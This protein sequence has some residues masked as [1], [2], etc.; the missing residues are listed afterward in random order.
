[1]SKDKYSDMSE[2]STFGFLIN[3]LDGRK[4]ADGDTRASFPHTDAEDLSRGAR[5]IQQEVT[6]ARRAGKKV[7]FVTECGPNCWYWEMPDG[8]RRCEPGALPLVDGLS[9]RMD[10]IGGYGNAIVPQVAAEFVK[11]YME[12]TA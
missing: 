8:R 12:A 4:G 5:Y 11:A 1:M 6:L 9:E 10:A 7:N 3:A 2:L